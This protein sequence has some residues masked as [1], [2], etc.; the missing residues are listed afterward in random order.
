MLSLALKPHA[1]QFHPVIDQPVAQ[2]FSDLALQRFQLGIDEFDHFAAFHIDQVIVVCFRRSFIAG[3]A[4]AKIVAIK[5]PS[6]FEQPY[7][8]VNRGNRNPRIDCDRA[9]IQI[10][11]IGVVLGLGQHPG[12]HPALI[13]N[14][15]AAFGAECFDIDW[16]VHG[17]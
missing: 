13:G 11:H 10:V 4:I 16:L 14:S 17:S 6:F 12:D 7:G 2:L 5:D 1:E 3:A 9:F 15:Q 8:S